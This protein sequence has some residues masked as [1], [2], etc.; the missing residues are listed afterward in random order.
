MGRRL[1]V[2]LLL[3]GAVLGWLVPSYLGAG[4]GD[5]SAS[6]KAGIFSALLSVLALVIGLPARRSAVE[7][8]STPA[9]LDQAERALRASVRAYLDEELHR[10]GLDDVVIPV[11]L[12]TEDGE[13][14]VVAASGELVAPLAVD[15]RLL[16]VGEPGAGKTTVCLLW[17][18]ALARDDGQAVPVL[19]PTT[20]W[21]PEYKTLRQWVAAWVAESVGVLANTA[22]YGGTAASGLVEDGRVRCVIDGLDELPEAHRGAVL[23]LLAGAG[24]KTPFVL[25][26]RPGPSRRLAA[27]T[28]RIRGL[29]RVDLLPTVPADA[30]A[31]LASFDGRWRHVDTGSLRRLLSTPLT[32]YLMR[33][34]YLDRKAGGDEPVERALWRGLVPSVF[35]DL[36]GQVARRSSGAPGR[37]WPVESAERWLSFLAR[38]LSEPT[39]ELRWWNFRERVPNPMTAPAV[40]VGAVGVQTYVA[41]AL[42]LGVDMRFFAL[43]K[44]FLYPAVGL[45]LASMLPNKRL[46]YVDDPRVDTSV[47]LS[48]AAGVLV[49]VLVGTS[50][51]P[52][53]GMAAGLSAAITTIFFGVRVVARLRSVKRTYTHPAEAVR[54][55][56]WHAL[57]SSGAVFCMLSVVLH[58]L[59]PQA[60]VWDRPLLLSAT[61]TL[62]AGWL[63]SASVWG[64][65]LG[66]R[67]TC[68]FRG[69]LP[70][71]LG[72]FL[73]DTSRIG[74]LQRVGA[75]YAF[76]HAR[77]RAVLVEDTA[78]RETTKPSPL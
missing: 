9:Q 20:S 40:I 37:A 53:T 35:E 12:R 71:R 48:F 43:L 23:D 54:T 7:R 42:V 73:D 77:L 63:L 70:W 14:L 60:I 41:Q 38:R 76:R 65:Y 44:S 8:V 21:R 72:A 74:L 11:R 56:R 29:R 32:V 69:Q 33:Q 75:H 13:R 78:P 47:S 15:A 3:G 28:S 50:Q 36:A 57:V 6:W 2:G 26:S 25:T 39:G 61:A 5:E 17:C 66:A 49:G 45:M 19:V 52:V 34:V 58:R 10:R 59:L 30:V 46:F 62:I 68:A 24:A 67:L 1:L 27:R 31:Y 22:E 16:L 51:G 18:R 64:G 55:A 4:G